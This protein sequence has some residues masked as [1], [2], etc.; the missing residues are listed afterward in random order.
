[1]KK[2]KNPPDEERVS[3]ERAT[4]DKDKT[5]ET[6]QKRPPVSGEQIQEGL[7][8]L[9]RKPGSN[10][11]KK[12]KKTSVPQGS[13][14]VKELFGSSRKP[15]SKQKKRKKKTSISQGSLPVKEQKEI[16]TSFL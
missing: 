4:K 13:L 6:E 3:E 8:G 16:A 10:Q 12:K 7:F 15:G 9:R 2:S 11:K 14:P 5:Q 1:M